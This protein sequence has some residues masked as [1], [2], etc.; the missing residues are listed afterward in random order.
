MEVD[1]LAEGV[2]GIGGDPALQAALGDGR[3]EV[4]VDEENW[5][6][7]VCVVV[8]ASV[9]PVVEQDLAGD[10]DEWNLAG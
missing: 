1:R 2:I 9:L 10:V 3:M 6:V 7:R 8:W 5:V 4:F